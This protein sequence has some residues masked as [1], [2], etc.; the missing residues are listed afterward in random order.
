MSAH[1]ALTHALRSSE[2]MMLLFVVVGERAY[3]SIPRFF[4]S[5]SC[6]SVT[7]GE[8]QCLVELGSED[9][10]HSPC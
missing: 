6:S 7:A 9:A 5:R 2:L 4:F 3:T 1:L 10:R 8:H